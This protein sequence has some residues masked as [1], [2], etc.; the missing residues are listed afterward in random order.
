MTYLRLVVAFFRSLK[1][2]LFLQLL[3]LLVVTLLFTIFFSL[4]EIL[5]IQAGV[6]ADWAPDLALVIHPE[7]V[8]AVN[9]LVDKQL[10]NKPAKQQLGGRL[11][12]LP[13]QNFLLNKNISFPI[14]LNIREILAPQVTLDLK[15]ANTNTLTCN[16]AS[17]KGSRSDWVLEV[18]N[19]PINSTLVSLDEI[20]TEVFPIANDKWQLKF[21]EED[22]TNSQRH[23]FYQRL[24]TTLNTSLPIKKS[25]IGFD[26]NAATI[27]ATAESTDL[28]IW[29]KALEASYNVA[30][31][32]IFSPQLLIDHNTSTDLNGR[33]RDYLQVGWLNSDAR[34]SPL[35][36]W[37]FRPLLDVN[38][39]TKK[40]PQFWTGFSWAGSQA[41]DLLL[42]EINQNQLNAELYHYQHLWWSNAQVPKQLIAELNKLPK[43]Y[44]WTKA[45]LDQRP[46]F[47]KSTSWSWLPL[48]IT[49]IFACLILLAGLFSF[50]QKNAEAL[51][52][53]RLQGQ[54][55]GIYTPLLFI[56]LLSSLAL[57][58]IIWSGWN[59]FFQQQLHWFHHPVY[60]LP[61][62]AYLSSVG[63]TLLLFLPVAVVDQL[64]VW[65]SE[66]HAISGVNDHA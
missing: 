53:L 58:F 47:N 10:V 50:H 18:E 46:V 3:T 30:Y 35:K 42:E 7:Q 34:P 32:S 45:E 21:S 60:S 62:S 9:T 44:S 8:L 54:N 4:P 1:L 28:L 14:T 12:H 38:A 15:I 19:C 39:S 43:V 23:I 63:L 66:K 37:I 31:P 16:L 36:S 13:H 61:L 27:N 25:G 29:Q 17:V 57:S 40:S 24:L 48:A 22:F 11:I 5:R 65:K 51:G 20:P 59:V 26:L 64:L 49:F 2:A 55:L 56:T 33:F 41:M 52:F 6:G